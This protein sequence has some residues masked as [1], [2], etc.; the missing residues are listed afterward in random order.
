MSTNRI[1]VPEPKRNPPGYVPYIEGGQTND[2][3]YA[4]GWNDCRQA[5][6]DLAQAH[7]T[8]EGANG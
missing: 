1:P 7:R 3:A 8:S 5:M 6:I 2:M 4:D